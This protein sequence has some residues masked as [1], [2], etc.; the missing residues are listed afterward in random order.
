LA[1][2]ANNSNPMH[3]ERRPAKALFKKQNH[4]SGNL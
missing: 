2:L 1:R 4:H 3:I